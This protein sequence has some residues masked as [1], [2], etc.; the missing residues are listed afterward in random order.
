VLD[1]KVTNKQLN[2]VTMVVLM[3]PNQGLIWC[4]KLYVQF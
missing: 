4:V 2:I 1:H 3:L